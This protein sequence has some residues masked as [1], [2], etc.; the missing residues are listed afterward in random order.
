MQAIANTIVPNVSETNNGVIRMWINGSTWIE[1]TAVCFFYRTQTVGW[2]SF[3][4]NPTY[5]GGAN[6]VPANQYLDIDHMYV[7]VKS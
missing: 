5:G 7:S 6:P 3:W 1:D 2:K 4:F